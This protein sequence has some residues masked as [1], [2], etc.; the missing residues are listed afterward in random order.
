MD[1][2]SIFLWKEFE[3]YIFTHQRV[4]KM[5]F[6][7]DSKT[8]FVLL[9]RRNDFRQ[10]HFD[11]FPFDLYGMKERFS[12]AATLPRRIKRTFE[13][14]KYIVFLF[15][16]KHVETLRQRLTKISMQDIPLCCN[17]LRRIWPLFPGLK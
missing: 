12:L 3:M 1:L 10:N 4:L 11:I 15:L 6:L 8:L 9:G 14:P 2:G 16:Q 5:K 13:N 17:T 7:T